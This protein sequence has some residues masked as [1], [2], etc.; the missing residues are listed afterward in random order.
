M[1]R[2]RPA[3]RDASTTF[4]DDVF[5]E[6]VSREDA[7]REQDF[8]EDAFRRLPLGVMAA[9]TVTAS[10]AGPGW[11]ESAGPLPWLMSLALVG[12]PHGATD[13]AAS[14]TAWRGGPLLA[15]WIVYVAMMAVVVVFF[16]AAPFP[17]IAAF[18]ALSCWHFGE[19][20]RDTD[21]PAVGAR[22]R[23]VAVLARGC[24]VLAMP[25]IAWPAATADAATDLAALAVGRDAAAH[26]FP[27]PTVMAAGVA[28]AIAAIIAATVEICSM[29]KRPGGW[30]ASCRM[31]VEVSVIA[32]LGWFTDPLFS[33]GL[34]FLAWH[35]W[36]QM[37]Q[38]AES[39]TGSP[40]RSYPELGRA[41]LRIHAAALPLLVPTWTAIGA[42]WWLCSG[43][44]SLRDLAIVSIGSYLIVTPSHELL[45]MLLRTT[46]RTPATPAGHRLTLPRL[47]GQPR[48]AR[49]C[50]LSMRG[51][52]E[53]CR[54]RTSQNMP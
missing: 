35:S 5:H 33:V 51:P 39:L 18:V 50:P 49:S 46:S 26:L 32:S 7:L 13:L 27:P 3:G 48:V 34:S 9:A 54:L 45:G 11:T 22:L 15:V 4:R 14:R 53:E 12:L 2:D 21:R 19:A 6:P 52:A 23:G 25:L 47:A 36:R 20:H 1:S 40:A 43:E 42:V 10:L 17:A 29:A 8:R 24:V 16:T 28:L 38:L 31:L 44:R 37:E 30:G 41:L